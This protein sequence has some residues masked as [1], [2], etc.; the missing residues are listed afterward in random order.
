MLLAM[1]VDKA[2]ENMNP[3]FSFS[4]LSCV[5]GA[6]PLSFDFCASQPTWPWKSGISVISFPN[7]SKA[8][9]SDASGVHGKYI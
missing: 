8:V 2:K 5:F 6:L 1:C 7:F 3:M 9:L 4:D